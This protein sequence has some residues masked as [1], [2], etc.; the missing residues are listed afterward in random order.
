MKTTTEYKMSQPHCQHI[1]AQH[2]NIR[3]EKHV[4]SDGLYIFT[5]IS[6]INIRIILKENII[7][8]RVH[9]EQLI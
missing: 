1:I 6:R 8:K 2:M 3:Y 5:L 4:F 7:I 9:N